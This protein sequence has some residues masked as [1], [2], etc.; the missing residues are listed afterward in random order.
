MFAE[1]DDPTVKAAGRHYDQN[2]I[3]MLTAKDGEI[4]RL[5]EFPD[6][7]IVVKA[8]LPNGLADLAGT[9]P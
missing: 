9:A 4:V 2:Y 6:A 1:Y 3:A 5:R 8:F 7:I